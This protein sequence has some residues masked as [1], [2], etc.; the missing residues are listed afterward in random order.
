MINDGTASEHSPWNLRFNLIRLPQKHDATFKVTGKTVQRWS[1]DTNVHAW[2]R[3][4]S[5]IK[6]LTYILSRFGEFSR[7]YSST[8]ISLPKYIPSILTITQLALVVDHSCEPKIKPD[9]D[10]L[11]R[12]LQ[13]TSNTL[14]IRDRFTC[15]WNCVN[16]RLL[17]TIH[18]EIGRRLIY[19]L[20]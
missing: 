8:P 15:G 1:R 18:K 7:Y 13:R 10:F 9:R 11:L 20:R 16:N 2:N 12:N 4:P 19:K 14:L 5:I 3:S 17:E 6:T